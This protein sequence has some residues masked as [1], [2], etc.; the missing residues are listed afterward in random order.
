MFV[1]E[2]NMENHKNMTH[3][4]EKNHLKS[5]KSTRSDVP[6][7]EGLNTFYKPCMK[8]LIDYLYI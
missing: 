4:H 8:R 2:N 7:Q 3:S 1:E 5:Q 6:P